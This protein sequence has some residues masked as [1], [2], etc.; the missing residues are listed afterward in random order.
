MMFHSVELLSSGKSALVPDPHIVRVIDFSPTPFGRY[1][2]DGPES[3]EA[4]REDVLIPALEKHS[5]V[6]LDVD[7]VAG[8][9][10]SFWEEAIGGLIRRGQDVAT[11]RQQLEVVTTERDLQSY[12]RLAWR[13]LSEAA[14]KAQKS[15]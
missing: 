14:Q 15:A 9:P 3:G 12:V 1:R 2:T 6:R 11:I 7:G 5:Q 8:L 4:F 10:S 13:Y